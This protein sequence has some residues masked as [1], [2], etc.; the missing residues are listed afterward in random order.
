[1][2]QPVHRLK[3]RGHA[4][5]QVERLIREG[6]LWGQRL[7]GER[8]LAA[9]LGVC[10]VTLRRALIQL[11]R[12]GLLHRHHGSGT[13]AADRPGRGRRKTARLAIVGAV[14]Y[15]ETS[16]WDFRAEMVRGLLDAASRAGARPAVLALDRPAEREAITDPAAMKGYDAFVCLG[17]EHPE[18]ISAL[19]SLDRGP[20][21]LLDGY[22]RGLPVTMVVDAGLEGMKAVTRHL[23]ALGHRRIAF[24]DCFNRDVLNPEKFAGY[25]AALTEKGIPADDALVAVPSGAD[26]LYDGPEF[27]RYD[28]DDFVN[29]A[30]ERFMRL[31]DPPTAII[32]FDDGRALPAVRA[33]ERRGLTV[34]ENFSVAGFGDQAARRGWSDS[35]TSC[36]I[37]PRKMGQEALHAALGGVGS[38]PREA[39]TIFVPTRL[40]I[41][42]STCPP[43]KGKEDP[44]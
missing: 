33:L 3:R 40:Q 14:H 6:Q 4:R 31:D 20:V 34:G 38:P 42:K 5:E 1:V 7:P 21:V 28:L 10:R 13:F 44:K 15:E 36:R 19:L 32:G 23:L 22:V 27:G 43:A 11:E 25:R 18:V 2:K 35:L 41:R 17:D 29:S 24:I 16:G 37:Y 39:R 9:R 8:E 30:V 26:G 12:E